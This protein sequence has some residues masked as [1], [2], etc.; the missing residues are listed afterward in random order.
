VARSFLSLLLLAPFAVAADPVVTKWDVPTKSILPC[1]RWADD[2]GEHAYLLDGDG[3]VLLKVVTATGKVAEK[4]EFGRKVGWIDESAEGLIVSVP[5]KGELWVL[6]AKLGTKKTI[7]VKGLG[8]AAS[9][10]KL[11][12]AVVGGIKRETLRVVDL[13]TGE[14]TPVTT[15]DKKFGT[16]L[17]NEPVVSPDGQNAFTEDGNNLIRFAIKDG[18][19]TAPE[20]VRAGSNPGHIGVSPDSKFVWQPSGGGNPDIKPNY[21]TAIYTAGSLAKQ[22][23]ILAVG[24]NPGPIGYDT[25]AE[26]FYTLSGKKNLAVFTTGGVKKGEYD[27]GKEKPRQ[28]LAHPVGNK[29]LVI[30]PDQVSFVELPKE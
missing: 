15:D 10:P 6:D 30:A 23:C 3:G 25:V 1:A 2:K 27:M 19:L 20:R 29:V 16:F 8:H 11:S 7:E 18:K 22:E 17:G 4:K 28:F 13:K 5:D 9:S 21:A 26:R 12:I 14:A 24:A